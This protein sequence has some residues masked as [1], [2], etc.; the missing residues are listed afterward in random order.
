MAPAFLFRLIDAPRDGYVVEVDAEEA[1][2][3][4]KTGQGLTALGRLNL[5][6]HDDRPNDFE[7]R[8]GVRRRDLGRA[9]L[10][11]RIPAVAALRKRLELPIAAEADLRE[12][13]S[14]EIDRLTPF[15]RTEVLFTYD[16]LRRDTSA[17]KLDVEIAAVPKAAVDHA[18]AVLARF[19]IEPE[20]VEVGRGDDRDTANG[21]ARLQKLIGSS[22]DRRTTGVAAWCL[23][24]LAFILA[25]LLLYLPL[26]QDR[27]AVDRLATEMAEARKQVDDAV[28]QR[29][30]AAAHDEDRVRL[31][32]R[33]K[34]AYT[35]IELL[36]EISRILP[37]NT[38]LTQLDLNGGQLTLIGNSAS[39]STV[40]SL[41]E[42]SAMFERTSFR[43]PI[44][45]DP[46][47]SGERFQ[48]STQISAR[49]VR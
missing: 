40:L 27:V 32:E 19:G 46:R 8:I 23:A 35:A 21:A 47:L 26:R 39:A 1:R 49:P 4:R 3:L 15:K 37:D 11:L 31:R 45:Q 17:S 28:Q 9:G 18:L 10:T 29:A 24:S 6:Q 2:F 38:H 5:T 42:E 16:V 48:I 34:R 36:E 25:V 22:E 12:V 43:A 14:F 33:R 13:L 30:E 41:I 44:T 7:N 20:A